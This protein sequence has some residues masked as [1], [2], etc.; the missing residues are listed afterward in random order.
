M[1]R[2]F[3]ELGFFVGGLSWFPVW[4]QALRVE[5]CV[6]MVKCM[7][8]KGVLAVAMG[9]GLRVRMRDGGGSASSSG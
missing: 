2:R 5:V 6:L 4:E 3:G 7:V 9:V 1:F 8:V